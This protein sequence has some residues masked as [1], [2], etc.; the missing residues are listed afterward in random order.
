MLPQLVV[1]DLDMC[2]WHP[3]MYTLSEL[4]V[5][6][7][8][9]KLGLHGEGV[10]AVYSGR[11]KVQLFPGALRVLQDIYLDCYPCV[12]IA[13]ASSADT[14]RAVQIARACMDT[15]EVLPGVTMRQVFAKGW[16]PGFE[17]N[18]QIGRSPPLSADKGATH[19]PRIQRETGIPY[20]QMLFFDDCN[21]DDNCR[22][23][24][25]KCP[26]VATQT[27]PDGLQESE[28]IAGLQ[29]FAAQK[30]QQHR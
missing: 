22:E 7:V 10:A 15:L 5:K 19:F 2:L 25:R 23:V 8:M 27:T 13:A 3:E 4:P 28:W 14:P 16:Q 6:P 11:R 26:G 18:I 24:A 21:W 17:G 30:Q 1:F 29:T 9:D 20:N 12:R